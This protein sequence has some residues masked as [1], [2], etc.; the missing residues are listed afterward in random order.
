MKVIGLTGSIGMGKSTTAALF[1][2]CRVPVFDADR[3]VH[4]AEGKGGSAVAAIAREFP[5]MVVDGAVDRARLGQLVF[6]DK[7]ALARLEAIL[8]PILRQQQ[9]GFIARARAARRP[10]VVLDIP[11]LLE[12]GGAKQ[13][14]LVIVVSCPGFLQRARVLARR[15]MTPARLNAI[16]ARQM[17]DRDKRRRADI[18][19]QTGL[20]KRFVLRQVMALCHSLQSGTG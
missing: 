18:I 20:G 9:A 6:Q 17:S 16:I 10:L 13:V 15:N 11:L 2:L 1:R 8:H 7:T 3:M 14:D 19:L 5:A 4:R 12:T